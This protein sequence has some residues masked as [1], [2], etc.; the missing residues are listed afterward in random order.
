[1]SNALSVMSRALPI[2]VATK[3]SAGAKDTYV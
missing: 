1:M 3:Y 2:G